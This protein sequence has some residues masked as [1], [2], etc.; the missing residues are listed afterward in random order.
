VLIV[1]NVRVEGTGADEVEEDDDV[2][3]DDDDELVLELEELDVTADEDDEEEVD[4]IDVVEEDGLEV[5]CTAVLV[6]AIVVLV[7]DFTLDI[8]N[9]AAPATIKMI[10][11]TTATISAVLPSPVF[12]RFKLRPVPTLVS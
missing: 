1:S 2:V 10:T 5:V 12:A 11:T 9:N 4:T 7:V 6:V 3:E 8:A